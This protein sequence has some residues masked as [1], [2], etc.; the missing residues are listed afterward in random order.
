MKLNEGRSAFPIHKTERMDTKSLH[1]PERT[2]N[3]AI[4]HNPHDHVHTFRHQGNKI[5]EVIVRRL[6]LRKFTIR[7]RFRGMNQIRELQRILNE[8]DRNVVADNIPVPLLCIKLDCETADVT[9]QV[10]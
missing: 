6:G 9:R 8:E 3:G 4:R 10:D 2:R 1:E 7:L 5:P